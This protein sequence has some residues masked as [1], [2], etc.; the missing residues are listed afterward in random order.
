MREGFSKSGGQYQHAGCDV[1]KTGM[2][3]AEDVEAAIDFAHTQPYVDKSFTLLVGQS[4]GGFTTLAYASGDVDPSVK[5]LINFAG[6]I[7]REE[8]VGW[9]RNLIHAVASYAEDTDVPSL[10]FYGDNDSYFSTATYRAMFNRYKSAQPATTLIAFGK[11]END[12]H[13]LFSSKTGERYGNPMLEKFYIPWDCPHEC[14]IHSI[15]LVR[16]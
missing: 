11:F 8:C 4:H 2:M 12:S 16:N 7:K 14:C 15:V 10:W 5:G 9:E 6:G 3:Q 1:E 13:N